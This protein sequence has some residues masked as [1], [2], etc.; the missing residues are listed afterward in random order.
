MG[1]LGEGEE[2]EEGGLF[3]VFSG[4]EERESAISWLELELN[5]WLICLQWRHTHTMT[6]TKKTRRMKKVIV[7]GSTIINGKELPALFLSSVVL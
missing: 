6:I 5:G 4:R 2:E 3:S 7:T 1:L